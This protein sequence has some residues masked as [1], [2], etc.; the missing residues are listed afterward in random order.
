MMPI[1]SVP[2][3]RFIRFALILALLPVSTFAGDWPFWGRDTSRNMVSPETNIPAEFSPGRFKPNSEEVDLSTTMNVKWTA[4]VGSET[5]GNVTVAGGKVFI[6]TNNESP[7]N[8]KLKGDRGVVQCY[9]EKTGAF[10]WQLTVP[11]LGAGK[12]SDWEYLGV[13]SS[14]AVEDGRVYIVTNRCE[15][16]CLDVEGLRNGNDGPFTDEALFAGGEGQP[17]IETGDHDADILWR[18]DMRE[19]LGVFPHNI[20]SSSVLIVGDRL[21]ATTSN[22]QDWS[23]LNIPSPFAPTLVCLDK[24]TGTLLGEEALGIS[25]RLYHCNWSSPAYGEVNGKG[26]VIFGAGDGFCYGLDPVPVSGEDGLIV[27]KEFWKFD[28]IPAEYKTYKYP[29]PRGPSEVIATPVFYNNRVYAAIGQDPEHGDGVGNLV[30]IDAS[31]TGDTTAAGSVWSFR[32]I[33]RTISTVSIQDGL[34]YAGS[35]RGIVYCLDAETGKLYWQHDTKSHIWGSTLVVDGKVFIGNEDGYLTVLAAGKEKK[36]L[37]E[38]D[39]GA[40]IFSTPVVAN[41]TLYVGTQTHLYAIAG[42]SR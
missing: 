32:D 10:L 5:F 2:W 9:D 28:C 36:M 38:I 23:H 21:Y 18:F 34:L 20:T 6:G 7:R 35:Y 27:F 31:K 26:M 42:K 40:A 19:E 24:R 30:C 11:K 15:V 17:P 33:G 14:P 22:G 1:F 16:V 3:Q 37:G 41:G 25:Q 13:C 8:S 12:V 29:D 39:F 4:K